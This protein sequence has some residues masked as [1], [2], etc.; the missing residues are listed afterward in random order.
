MDYFSDIFTYTNIHCVLGI[1]QGC[2]CLSTPMYSWDK[3]HPAICVS[4]YVPCLDNDIS[5]LLL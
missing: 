1:F 2:T 4:T 3:N 5:L